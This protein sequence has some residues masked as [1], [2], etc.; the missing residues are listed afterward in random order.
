VFFFALL[1]WVV[2]KLKENEVVGAE[3]LK[4]EEK[5]RGGE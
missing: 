5:C 3:E 2:E 4:K 1:F